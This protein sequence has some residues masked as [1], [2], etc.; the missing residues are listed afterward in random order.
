MKKILIVSGLPIRTDTNTGKTLHVLFSKFNKSEI[1]QLY[2]HPQTPNVDICSSYYR[3]TEKQ[4]IKS[5]F[6]V[7]NKFGEKVLPSLRGENTVKPEKNI[8]FLT[9][10]KENILVR[11][12]R[13]IIWSFTNWKNKDFIEWLEQEQ[14]DVIFS[15]MQD[16]NGITKLVTWIAKKYNIPVVLF[17][18]DDYYNDNEMNKNIIRKL[19]FK[20]RK[21]LNKELAKYCKII[22]G[23]SEKAANY[24]S[25]ELNIPKSEV[26]YTPSANM[27]LEMPYKKQ[28][29]D[30]PLKIR[31]FGNLG[32]GR[33][34][35]LKELGNVL[36]RINENK[37]TSVCILEVY[38]SVKDQD[39]IKELNIEN[40]CIYKGWVYGD[41]YL[42]LLQ[43][44]DI[45][46]HVESFDEA[47]IRRTWVSISTKIADYLG[48]GKCILGIGSKELAS[49]DHIKEVACVVDDLD[50][51]EKKLSNLINNP[52]LRMKYQKKARDLSLKKHNREIISKKLKRML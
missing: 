7:L 15:I 22:V 30:R 33:W 13:E 47:M 26:L 51:L 42:S 10:F 49:I 43:E 6:G 24:F 37:K 18:T 16:V 40:G 5:M 14:P 45:A 4:I 12:A 25:D 41:S 31:Y 34:K 48:A 39:I 27:Y 20:K 28:S 46:V 32:L 38:S 36:R 23:C 9:K 2:F 21:D 11:I 19:Y 29:N 35:I 44:T 52:V 1:I 50:D 3:I 17:I 8:I